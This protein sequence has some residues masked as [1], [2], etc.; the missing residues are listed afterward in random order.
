ML[1]MAAAPQKRRVPAKRSRSGAIYIGIFIV[2]LVVTT[3]AVMLG[4]SD[5]GTIDVSKVLSE[6]QSTAQTGEDGQVI[7]P[8]TNNTPKVPNG[9]LVG[10]GKST[11]PPPPPPAEEVAGAST[12]PEEGT[13]D[14]SQEE[15]EEDVE[16]EGEASAGD[17][18]GAESAEEDT[19]SQ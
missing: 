2:G 11:V 10:K 6:A 14:G 4:R 1:N 17:E 15:T 19:S 16:T 18:A 8:I 13:E 9:G 7:P 12:T 5:S 3:G